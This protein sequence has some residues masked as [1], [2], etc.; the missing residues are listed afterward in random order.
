MIAVFLRELR[1]NLKWAAV[2]CGVLLVFV[3]HE[4]RDTGPQ[5]L[6]DFP[7]KH[8]L[9]IAPLAGLLM[10]IVQMLFET[11]P[12]NW[13]FVVHRP[14]SREQIFIAK[15]AA[16]LLLLYVSLIVPCMLAWVWAARP[17]NLAIPFQGRMVLP[18][19]ADVLNGGCYYFVGMLV[20][21]RRARWFGS[22][23]L[24]L[25]IALTSSFLIT[26]FIEQF[27]QVVLAICVVE[28]IG[29]MAAW[30]IFAANG[31][32]PAWTPARLALGAMIY[33]GAVAVILGLIG[34]S[35]AFNSG[36]RW[37]YYQVDRDGQVVLV[38]QT[39]LHGERGWSFTD[40]AGNLLPQYAGMDLD[41]P[42][43]APKFVKFN[44]HLIDP[45]S[46]PWPLSVE[47]AA[48]GYRSP[49]PGIEPLRTAAPAGV[50]LPFAPL[51]DVP[52]RIIDLYDPVTHMQIG[53]VGPAGF[54]AH[55]A[56]PAQR[57]E[58]T[59]LNL[60]LRG[61]HTLAFDS[62]VYWL[63]LD[64]RRLKPI[65][66]APANDPV[67][68]AAEV[69]TPTDP[70]ALVATRHSLHLLRPDGTTLFTTA[71]PSDPSSYYF[72]AA[73][74]PNGHLIVRA[75]HVP[76][77]G[78]EGLHIFEYSQ[79]GALVRTTEPPMLSDPRSP[80]R[81]ET[82]MFGAVFPLAARPI[83]AGWILDDVIDIRSEDFPH[84]FEGFMW[85]SAILCAALSLLIGR[86]CGLG[87]ARTTGWSIASLLL[88]P[89]GTA[90]ML[91]INDWAARERCA[92]C[93]QRRIAARRLCTTCGA[94]QPAADLDG[95]EIFDP[96]DEFAAGQL[97]SV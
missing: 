73:L 26:I 64:Q 49:N 2:I 24:P 7:N 14:V 16:G 71:M 40:P 60:F 42:A 8:T 82:M 11:K 94:P 89:A 27:W 33:P 43:N 92:A 84:L 57:F 18:M 29:A 56:E 69:G 87:I 54:A 22:R 62:Q 97:L 55:P 41:D 3:V 61:T 74:L 23:L 32:D 75:I 21:L 79:S 88:G 37:Q 93:G 46:I 83:I 39:I 52:Q 28:T 9:F 15:C 95:R 58:G 51:Y 31:E 4:I 77:A 50:R 17:G 86:R 68:S 34:F 19:L 63:Q 25:G 13:G 66:T 85:G 65:F 72:D 90:V 53:T 30:G 20:T 48:R 5:F 12:D 67:F 38:T 91:S 45:G 10:G 80:K 47:F 70:K 78:R 81:Y 1:E 6:F 59:P 36:W 35:Q 76:G 44:A 96:A